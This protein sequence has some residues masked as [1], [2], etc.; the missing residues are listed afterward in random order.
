LIIGKAVDWW[1]IGILL[2]EMLSGNPPFQAD[3]QKDLDK[4]IMSEKLKLPTHASPAAHSILKGLLE[5]DMNKRL[6]SVKGNMFTIGGVSA[7][8]KHEFFEHM[9]WNA[10][11]KKKVLKNYFR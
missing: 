1:A 3:N 10:L 4:K 6:G 8:K 9:D 5:K 11:L 7:L 2:Y